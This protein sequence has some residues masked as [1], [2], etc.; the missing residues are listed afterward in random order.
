[1]SAHLALNGVDG[2][3]IDALLLLQRIPPAL[4]M[5][6]LMSFGT[7]VEFRTGGTGLRKTV[8]DVDLCLPTKLCYRNP[9]LAESN[10]KFF[11]TVEAITKLVAG[12]EPYATP[13]QGPISVRRLF[14]NG[15]RLDLLDASLGGAALCWVTRET[16][17][18]VST[19]VQQVHNQLI[20][21]SI[22]QQK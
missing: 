21:A 13:T 9:V 15:I 4:R 20:D 18:Q 14:A 16:I 8:N 2:S 1:V 3:Y 7:L 12:D 6:C 19:Q 11:K 22:G 10:H 17:E 5:Q